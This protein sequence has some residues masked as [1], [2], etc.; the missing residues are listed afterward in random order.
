MQGKT[1]QSLYQ[2]FKF[3]SFCTKDISVQ[4]LNVVLVSGQV[5]E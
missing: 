5:A 2:L 4:G 1:I 3:V